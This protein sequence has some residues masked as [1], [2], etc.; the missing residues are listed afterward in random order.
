MTNTAILNTSNKRERD[1]E[2]ERHTMTNT[3]E[4]REN[5]I[6]YHTRI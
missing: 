1:R 5:I 2:R 4:R 6:L 3:E